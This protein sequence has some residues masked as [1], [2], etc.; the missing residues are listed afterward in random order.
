MQEY[1]NKF[2]D[3]SR[4]TFADVLTEPKRVKKYVKKMDPRVKIYVLRYGVISFQGVY[5][6]TLN[7]HASLK[8]EEFAKFVSLKKPAPSYIWSPTKKSRYE[9]NCSVSYSQCS[10]YRSS[11]DASKCQKCEKIFH[12]G[13]VM[14]L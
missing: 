10:G 1:T 9:L 13:C 7:I 11:Y 2:T 8:E 14:A 5:E 6:I 12:P 3:L 4:L